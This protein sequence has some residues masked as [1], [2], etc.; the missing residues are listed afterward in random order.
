MILSVGWAGFLV[1]PFVIGW[2]KIPPGWLSGGIFVYTI[3]VFVFVHGL[4]TILYSV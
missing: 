2:Q 3:F 1:S 4:Y